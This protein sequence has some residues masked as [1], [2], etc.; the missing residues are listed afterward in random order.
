[1]YSCD[2]IETKNKEV[3]FWNSLK[4]SWLHGPGWLLRGSR[5]F[6]RLHYA[7]LW[8]FCT[9]HLRGNATAVVCVVTSA[10]PPV[11]AAAARVNSLFSCCML[12]RDYCLACFH[13]KERM[14]DI[15]MGE[16]QLSLL[17]DTSQVEN[18]LRLNSKLSDWNGNLK[19]TTI[20][21]YKSGYCCHE[22][23]KKRSHFFCI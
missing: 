9:G 18:R 3:C 5:S 12:H 10:P 2:F 14:S 4:H 6:T 8:A 17:S 21:L 7:R 23:N 16:K 22:N 1:M 20:S 19:A 11:T 15:W 13:G